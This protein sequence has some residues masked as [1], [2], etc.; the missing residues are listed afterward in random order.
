MTDLTL[1]K[2]KRPVVFALIIV[3]LILAVLITVGIVFRGQRKQESP[4]S[5]P[6]SVPYTG[7]K[8][9]QPSG[10]ENELNKI[11]PELPRQAPKYVVEYVSPINIIN[12]KISATS[13][14]DYLKTKLEAES[15]LKG[16]GV[17]D[18]CKLS[19][20]WIAPKDS[21]IR[22]SMTPRDLTTTGCP[23]D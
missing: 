15:Y 20:F 1:S 4:E 18:L 5:R 8:L 3:L 13:K 7:V 12:V 16:K 23:L 6:T 11:K 10:F 19:I 2:S 21:A 9:P 14:E 22:K 17:Q